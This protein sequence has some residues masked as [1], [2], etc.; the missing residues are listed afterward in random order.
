MG[1]GD[2]TLIYNGATVA[3]SS[4]YDGG[5][6][7]NTL[8]LV[9]SGDLSGAAS[10]GVDGFINIE[11]IRFVDTSGTI[12][13]TFAAAQFGPGKISLTST[14]TGDSRTQVLI[15]NLASGESLDL[16]G[17]SFSDWTADDKIE[18][19][20]STGGETIVGTS[21]SDTIFTGGGGIDVLTGGGGRDTFVFSALNATLLIGGGGGNNGSVTGLGRI[22]D[23]A[24]GRDRSCQRVAGIFGA[25]ARQFLDHQ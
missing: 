13:A 20:G 1:A 21:Q 12:T 14:I 17:L 10:D 3:A 7:T 24:P 18:I 2:D 23:F 16:S 15:V 19:V 22:T 25:L 6:G 11:G 8:Q 5:D 4:R 9:Q